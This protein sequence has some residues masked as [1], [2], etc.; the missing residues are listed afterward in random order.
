MLFKPTYKFQI[1]SEDHYDEK[2]KEIDQVMNSNLKKGTFESYDK[3]KIYYEYLLCENAKASVVIVH[4]YTEFTKK[5]YELCWYMVN[6][7]YNVFMYDA[8]G[9]GYSYR[10]TPDPQVTYIDN[11]NEYAKD[12]NLF[13][14]SIVIPASNDAP[15]YLYSHS[16]GGATAL[17]Y[18]SKYN[19][20]VKKAILS[21]PM[22]YP[23]TFQL[24]R[25]ILMNLIKR[26]AKKSGWDSK[27]K[28][29]S[30]FNPKAKYENSSDGS[31]RRFYRNLALRIKEPLFQNSAGTNRWMY[32]AVR[33]IE[34]LSD[35]KLLKNIK[36]EV[37]IMTADKD[38]VVKT[39]QHIKLSKRLKCKIIHFEN[40]KHSL[41]T[42]KDENLEKYIESIFDF[43]K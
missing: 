43:L 2:I 17:L 7:G 25:F 29:S 24:P 34:E 31:E 32:E 19:T 1:I 5:Y 13:I 21:A 4:G 42:M 18:M 9:H 40:A 26:E 38:T 23:V 33:I 6:M 39:N 14:N 30:S 35:K 3:N 41:Y 27:F 11:Y 36:A 37:L 22:I 12:L 10:R 28:F 15:I 20:P 16:L 8:R